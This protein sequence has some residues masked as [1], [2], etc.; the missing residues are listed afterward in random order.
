M[1]DDHT[2]KRETDHCGDEHE[3]N[4]VSPDRAVGARFSDHGV[5]SEATAWWWL[6]E[7]RTV[8]LGECVG[9]AFAHDFDPTSGPLPV[10]VIRAA[11]PKDP[12][13][14]IARDRERGG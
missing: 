6:V 3:L 2:T 4:Q 8:G 12:D 10:P 9:Q 13:R 1:P 5:Q 7:V 11:P 14:T